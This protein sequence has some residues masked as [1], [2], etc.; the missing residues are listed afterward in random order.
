MSGASPDSNVLP[1]EAAGAAPPLREPWGWIELFA[2]IQLLWGVLLFIPGAQPYR[3]IVRALPYVTSLAALLFVLR[4]R[5]D[6]PI[7]ASGK[8]LLAAFA[9][10]AMNLLHAETRVAAGIAQVIFQIGV[11][12]PMFWMPGMTGSR[13]RLARLLSVIFVA[14]FFS[15]AI[16]V[17]QVYYPDSLLPPEFSALARSLNPAIVDA[18]SYVGPDGRLIIRPPGLSDLPGGAALAGLTTV[19]FAVGYV[20][21]AG[22]SRLVRI[23]SAG[24]AA[25]GM[26]ALYLTQVRS[27]TVVAALG[28]LVYALVRL[29]QGRVLQVG[30]LVL[31]GTAIVA[32]S[33]MW[34]SAIG[35]K[36]IE[37]RFSALL[38]TGLFT[39]FQENRGLFL[40]Y[41][42][43][44]LLFR[45]PFGAGLGRWGMMNVYFPDPSM[46]HAPPIH[47]E[48]Q[49]TGWLL[50]GGFPMWIFYGGALA[51]A[52]A[53]AY[54]CAR[55]G[56]DQELSYLAG[57]VLTFQAS[58]IALCLTGPVFNTQLGVLFWTVTGALYGTIYATRD[59]A[60]DD[61]G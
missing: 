38:G 25:V 8:W 57:V 15:A 39:T 31:G 52:V 28:V 26:T 46:W 29:R 16:G 55:G 49:P 58:V 22:N 19:L 51:S 7:P 5:M 37:T 9:L 53:L 13:R 30:W 18:L 4:R 34:A 40:N 36:T 43:S 27:L 3:V 41:T 11:A 14:S 61:L 2:A 60:A 12:A 21:H 56:D 23:A 45:F 48:I 17:L 54:R 6:V 50:D 59:S 44:D 42:F 32:M 1:Y 24:A 35:G 33:F 47:V 20:S 10:L